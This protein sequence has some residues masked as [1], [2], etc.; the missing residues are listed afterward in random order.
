MGQIG[1]LNVGAGDNKLVFDPNDMPGMIRAARV[2]NDMIRRGYALLVET[3]K[4]KENKPVYQRVQRFDDQKFEYIIADFDPVT[5]AA[6]DTKEKDNGEG[7]RG[8]EAAEMGSETA[9][10]AGSGRGGRRGA[11]KRLPAGRTSGIAVG[12]TA[13]G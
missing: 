10:K 11:V 12:R 6:E 5:A 3:G 2:V 1:I 13:G 9:G 4:D 7:V 8:T